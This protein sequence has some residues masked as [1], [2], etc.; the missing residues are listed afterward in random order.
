MLEGLYYDLLLS[1]NSNDTD[2]Y[3]HLSR[4]ANKGY[5]DKYTKEKTHLKSINNLNGRI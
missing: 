4:M 3:I 1:E 2:S 5:T